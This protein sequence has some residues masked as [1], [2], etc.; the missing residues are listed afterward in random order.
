M[1][2]Y[3]FSW[4]SPIPLPMRMIAH[5]FAPGACYIIPVHHQTFRLSDEPRKEPIERLEPARAREPERLASR[6]VGETFVCPT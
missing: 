3:L 6:R 4:K 2:A 1:Y 5:A